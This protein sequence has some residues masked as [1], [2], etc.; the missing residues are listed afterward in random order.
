VSATQQFTTTTV[1]SVPT[2]PTT[3]YSNNNTAQSGQT[4]PTDITDPSP[5]FS[6]IYEDPDTGDIANKY[7][8]EVNTQSDFLGT[9]MWD[10]GATGTSMANTTAGNRSPDIIYAGSAL[11]DATTYYWRITFWDDGGEQGAV[12]ATQ[13]FT[14]TTINDFSVTKTGSTITVDD[15]TRKWEFMDDMVW[16]PKEWYHTSVGSGG[17]NLAS[18]TASSLW[19]IENQGTTTDPPVL[20]ESSSARARV[21][22][23]DGSNYTITTV[24]PSGKFYQDYSLD[25]GSGTQQYGVHRPAAAAPQVSDR[26]EANNTVVFGDT[27]N[28]NYAGMS[29]IPYTSS[30]GVTGSLTY[31]DDQAS[32]K[33]TY[34]K[35]AAL[36]GS[37][38]IL[39]DVSEYRATTVTR[40]NT[41]NDYRNPSELTSF[42]TGSGGWFD[43]SENTSTG[44]WDSN[45]AYRRQ[46]T[47]DSSVSGYSIKLSITDATASAIYNNCVDQTNGNDLRVVWWDGSQWNDLDRYLESFS[48]SDITV[49]FRIQEAGGWGGGASNYYLYYGNSSP[50]AVKADKSNIYD[51]WDD[52]DN[53]TNWTKWQDD[54]D[55][56]LVSATV[57]SSVVTIDAGASYLGGLKHNT[58]TP[59]NTYGFVARVRT[60]AVEVSDDHAPVCWFI[61]PA[62]ETYAYQTRASSTRNR[63]VRK[64]TGCSGCDTIIDEDTSTGPFPVADTWYEYEVHRLTDGTMRA[65]RDGTQQFPPGG[66]WSIANTTTTSGDFGIGGESFGGED[67]KFDWIWARKLVD[68][69]PSASA[70][71]E[72]TSSSGDFFNEAEGSYAIEMADDQK[73]NFDIDGSN[74]NRYSPVFKIRNYRSLDDPGAVYKDST[75][76]VKGSEYAVGVIPFS[77]AWYSSTTTPNPP[78][79]NSSY[80]YRKKITVS[81]GS[82]AIPSGYPVKFSFDHKSLVDAVPSKSFAN[83]FNDNINSSSWNDPSGTTIMF[84]TQAQIAA[85]TSDEGY[86]LYYDY[87]SATS[88]PTNTLSSRYFLAQD[89]GE[90]QTSSTTYSSK[91]QLQFTPSSTDEHWVVVATWRQ[92]HVAS[93]ATNQWAGKGRISLNSS[94]RTGTDEMTYRM[95]GGPWKTFQAFLKITGTTSQQTVDIDFRARQGPD[96]IDNARI[97]AFLIPGDLTNADIKYDEA[98]TKTTDSANYSLE[99]T[100]TPSKNSVPTAGDY[101]WMVNGFC[102]EAPGGATGGGLFAEDET[103]TDQQNGKDSYITSTGDG[104]VPLI[105]FERRP[106]L[107]ASSKTFTIR[108]QPDTTSG[109]E[110]QGLTQLLFRTDVFDGVEVASSTG[111]TNAT[112]SYQTKN[113][114]TTAEFVG[115]P[116]DYVYLVVMGLAE[117]TMDINLSSFGEIRLA[118]TQQLEDEVAIDRNNYYRQI[119]W[120]WAENTTGN[121]DIDSRIKEET[122]HDSYGQ[123]AHII[124]LRYIEPTISPDVEEPRTGGTNTQV[125]EGGLS[126]GSSEYL[127]RS[128]NNYTLTFDTDEYLY[129]GSTSKF[130]GINIDLATPGSGTSPVI[131]WQ[132]YNGAWTNLS[133]SETA[134]GTKDFTADGCVY[135]SQPSDWTET[136]INNGTSLYYVRAYLSG[137]DYST[138]SPVENK[139]KTDILL[140]QHL[141]TITGTTISMLGPTAVDLVDFTAT[142]NGNKVKVSWKTAME[143]NNLGFN[144]YRSTTRG[145]SYTKLNSSLIPGELYSAT[146]K[147]YTYDDHNVTK[148]KLYYYKLEDIDTFGKHRWHGPVCVDWDADGMPDDWELDHGLDPTV[149]DGHL[150]YDNDGLTN[151][152]EYERGTDPFNPDYRRRRHP[153]RPGIRRTPHHTRGRRKRRWGKR[154]LRGREGYCPRAPHFTLRFHGYCS[155][156]HGLPAARHQRLHPRAHRDGGATGSTCPRGWD[157]SWRWRRWRPRPHRDISST[158]CPKRSPWKRR[159]SRSSRWIRRPTHG[160]ASPPRRGPPRERSPISGTRRRPR[161]CSRPFRST[162][163]RA[164]FNFT[165]SSG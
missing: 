135:F 145:G 46:L 99:T 5:A 110:R 98:L 162:P 96:A 20:L 11:A 26:D 36:S 160:T 92:R 84:K 71:N 8:V 155:G 117:V 121:R 165:P 130:T 97:L 2:A 49:W 112:T 60:N 133:V 111:S 146:G 116:H 138:Q 58:Y 137:G 61:N 41:R 148:G 62:A 9:V 164:S 10:S 106:N 32:D 132:Y 3:P 156:W 17:D 150:D 141:G 119:A 161:Y 114:L 123:Y 90:T 75:L 70:G 140:L 136:S 103:G 152:E 68:P 50:A 44:W 38:Q 24:Y 19:G 76:L 122:G 13:Q 74:P 159:S 40:D 154:D 139:I 69:E 131:Q 105:H 163:R 59:G 77:E 89:L 126:S 51:L 128:D 42:N 52:F 78:W 118:G 64:D 23:K 147:T 1:N 63:Y 120:A 143:I 85:S 39:F 27:S 72:E 79:W 104:F 73:L 115:S 56:S 43:S 53:I 142:G 127:T 18:T 55:G 144:L 29:I 12:S 21:M 25:Y 80:D 149:N 134:S 30:M 37:G 88:P 82:K 35:T 125:A 7:R 4:N 14:T 65:F 158:P 33:H 100:F 87:P 102:H 66:G 124:S 86:Y 15:S 31:N 45:Y 95:A 28:N 157:S 153:R 108:H 16:G 129:L 91:V 93:T 109:S 22:I 6:A 48:S 47:I 113:T 57:N 67:Y 54:S 81:A 83:G 34:W 107:T 151:Y 101:I 94:P